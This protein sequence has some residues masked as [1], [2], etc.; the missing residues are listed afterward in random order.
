MMKSFAML[1]LTGAF[2]AEYTGTY[3]Y[4]DDEALEL[5]N[6]R[7]VATGVRSHRLDLRSLRVAARPATPTRRPAVFARGA[8]PVDTP[9]YPRESVTKLEGPAIIEAYDSTIVIPPGCTATADAGGNV[10]IALCD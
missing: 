10:V 1:A 5:V 9:V 8:A 7:L 4:A 6:L 3:G 2:H